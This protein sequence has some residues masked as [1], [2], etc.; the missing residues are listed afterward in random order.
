VL[1]GLAKA[2]QLVPLSTL[3]NVP[4][5]LTSLNN[6]GAIIIPADA[7]GGIPAF[8]AEYSNIPLIAVKENQTVLNITNEKMQMRNVI[9][10]NS[11]LEAAGVVVALREGISLESLR[12]PITTAKRIDLPAKHPQAIVENGRG[13]N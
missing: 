12:R 13:Y 5:H 9:E 10:V 4:T 6:I 2:P 8:A 1:K 3:E 7:L 11:Y